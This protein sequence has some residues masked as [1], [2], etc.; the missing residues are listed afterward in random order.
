MVRL[1]DTFE[2]QDSSSLEFW[3]FPSGW[4]LIEVSEDDLHTFISVFVHINNI[5]R[6]VSEDDDEDT[7]NRATKK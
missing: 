5:F 2:L 4:G 3:L 6:Q 1:V 7:F